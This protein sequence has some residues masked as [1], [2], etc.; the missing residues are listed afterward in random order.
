M[1]TRLVLFTINILFLNSAMYIG[2]VP[3]AKHQSML[4]GIA[5]TTESFNV[6]VGGAIRHYKKGKR[7]RVNVYSKKTKK[8]RTRPRINNFRSFN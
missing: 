4:P 1:P 2:G 6:N 3:V 8:R 7:F 5:D